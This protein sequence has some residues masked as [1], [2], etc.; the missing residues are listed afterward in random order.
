MK[1]GLVN[2]DLSRRTFV[3]ATAV[4]LAFATAATVAGCGGNTSGTEEEGNGERV[5]YKSVCRYCGTGCGILCE[6]EGGRL[7]SVTGD[8]D[9]ASSKGLNCIKGIYLAQILY[10]EDRLTVPLIRDDA[11]TKGTEE[12]LREASWDEALDLVSEKLKTAWQNDKSRIAFWGSGQQPITEGY[13]LAKFWKAGLLS[14]N[15]DPNA[16]LCMA[17]AVV[18]FMN[19]FQTDEPPGSYSDL[20]EADVFI[21]W[22]A[23]MAEAHPVLYSRLSARK[24][25]GDGIKHYDLTTLITSTSKDADKVILFKPGTDLAIA[26]AII[27]YLIQNNA[28][29]TAFVADHVQFKT[30]AENL[31]NSYEDGYDGSD[32]GKSVNDVQEVT[33]EEFAARVSEYSFEY[34]EQLSGVSAADLQ[35]IAEVFAN[36]DLK[37]MSLWT[38]GVN[39]HSR[40]TWMN[41]NI[42]NIHLLSGK[43]CK[44]GSGPFSLTGQPTACGTAREVGLFCHRLPSDLLVANPQH[45]RYT[46]A[47]WDLPTGYL[48]AIEVPGFHTIKI[49]REMSKGNIDFLWTS[50]NN[51]AASLPNLTRF[52]GVNPEYDG[53]FKTFIVVN[54]VYPTKSTQ[55]AD[56]VFPV[57]MWVEREGQ[58][59]NAERRTTI[60]EKAVDAPGEAQWDVWTYLQVAKRVLDGTE[61]EGV[62][63]FEH[64]FGFIWDSDADD[65]DGDHRETNRRLFEEYRIFT[66]PSLKESAEAINMDETGEFGAKLKM[67]NKQLAPYDE[68][69][70]K[71]GLTWPVREVDGQWMQTTWRFANGSQA[72][73]FDEVGIAQYGTE[74]LTDNISF[75][76]SAGGRPSVCFRPYEPPAFE[77]NEEYPFWFCTGRLLEQWHTGSMTRRVAELDRALPEALLDM[78]E[79][80]CERLGIQDGDM[81]RVTSQYG[82]VEIKA[83]TAKRTAPPEGMCF[84]PFFQESVL[85]N[86]AVQ[87]IYCPLSKEPDYK[88]TIVRIEKV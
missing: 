37:V 30:G 45:R 21:T 11:S 6:V 47:V 59:G 72:D 14:N 1:K 58:Y 35:E 5:T 40:G 26:N 88:K 34:V 8:P 36:P 85:V 16:R 55:Y 18:A 56:V 31:G 79:A 71:N 77:P 29:D 64:L 76:K 78:N 39:Q 68:Y 2:M 86:L 48:D 17:S 70:D 69:L 75:Y 32:Q 61:I 51:W 10:G 53:V 28:Y 41:H 83:S 7:V 38:M 65:F 46:E 80:D 63:T 25:S 66:N 73:G 60:F 50:T 81:V 9:N 13:A 74:G 54:E 15:I 49:F 19:T 43:I 87:D 23:N 3:K 20:D 82:T 27:N 42:Y 33:F 44:P 57:A 12:G 4:S 67:E 84:A 22:G 24:L 62:P 52:L